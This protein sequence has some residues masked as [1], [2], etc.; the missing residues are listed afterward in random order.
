MKES[1][2]FELKVLFSVDPSPLRVNWILRYLDFMASRGEPL[3]ACP[4]MY[5]EPLDLYRLYRAVG[6]QGG[7]R[8]CTTN[9]AWKK[10]SVKMTDNFRQSFLWRLLQKQYRKYLLKFEIFDTNDGKS[11][12]LEEL[13]Q[14]DNQ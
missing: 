11:P 14:L 2:G 5:K 13:C 7:F 6:D 10:V 3:S 12:N 9:K 1:R 8:S 4:S